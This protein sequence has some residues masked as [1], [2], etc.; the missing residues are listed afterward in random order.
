LRLGNRRYLS[1]STPP[2]YEE[3]RLDAWL[4]GADWKD[5]ADGGGRACAERS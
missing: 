3:A 4:H 2:Q 1:A 5:D